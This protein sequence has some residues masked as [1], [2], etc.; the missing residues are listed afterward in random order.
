M[1]VNKLSLKKKDLLREFVNF[2]CEECN[3][4]EDVVGRLQA[5]RLK[6]GWDGGKYCL[7]NILMVCDTCHKKFH[8]FQ[9]PH[10]SKSA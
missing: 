3:K 6:E 9:F 7:R 8:Q 2:T 4:H 1:E 10:I 5:H